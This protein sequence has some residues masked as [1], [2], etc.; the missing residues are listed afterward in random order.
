[1]TIRLDTIN[2]DCFR[3]NES[4]VIPITE[5]N[6]KSITLKG[7]KDLIDRVSN[8]HLSELFYEMTKSK[9]WELLNLSNR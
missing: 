6:M 3:E 1:M 9:R 8:S 4:R 2:I 5:N 7:N